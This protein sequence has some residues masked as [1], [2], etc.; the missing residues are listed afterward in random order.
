M[1][2]DLFSILTARAVGDLPAAKPAL[3]ARFESQEFASGF[4][5]VEEE[6]I[7]AAP[8]RTVEPVPGP[9][10][11][12]PGLQTSIPPR[13]APV[14]S[15]PVLA[16]PAPDPQAPPAPPSST[17]LAHTER[18]TRELRTI[19]ER[20]LE[21]A[22]GPRDSAQT[23]PAAV[24]A[25]KPAVALPRRATA[26][27]LRNREAEPQAAPH[28]QARQIVPSVTITIGKIEV[29]G[30]PQPAP[31]PMSRPAVARPTSRVS[32]SLRDYLATRGK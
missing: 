11:E 26:E 23:A 2:N 27:P 8:A 19:L 25:A 29:K 6:R 15:S 14:V 9:P 30:P 24:L 21:V 12:V 7:A 28:M 13:A 16:T 3:P 31:R 10:S 1:V 5:T 22:P 17:S 32:V 20:A 18:H 4:E